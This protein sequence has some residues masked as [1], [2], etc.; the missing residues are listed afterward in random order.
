MSANRKVL[1]SGAGSESGI[2]FAAAKRFQELGYQ[3]LLTGASK[4]VLERASEL[5]VKGF[6]AD[7]TDELQVAELIKVCE[8]SLNGL[9]VLVNNAGMT[10]V[11]SPMQSSG[12][13]ASVFD[14]SFSNW[15]KSISRNLDSAFLLTKYALPLLR[16]S[17]AGRIINISSVTGSLMAMK[18][19]AGYAAAKAGLIGLTRSLALDEAKFGITVNAVSP[20][21][22]ATG[23]QTPAEQQEGYATPLGRSGLAVEVA[24]T[25]CWIADSENGYLTGQN[26]VVDGGNSISEERF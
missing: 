20:G 5:S 1:V 18:N 2:G 24:A 26:I 19:D 7:L 22:I 17:T 8:E 21:W 10:S 11:H 12:E 14:L 16:K 13:T 6:V 23:S 9:D 15:Q 25:I 4:R 3:V